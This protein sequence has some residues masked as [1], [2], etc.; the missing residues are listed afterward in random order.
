MADEI[1]ADQIANNPISPFQTHYYQAIYDHEGQD[2]KTEV[3]IRFNE[4]E[5][6]RLKS[7]C[8]YPLRGAPFQVALV[9]DYTPGFRLIYRK[10]GILSMVPDP[11]KPGRLVPQ[12]RAYTYIIGLVE[13]DGSEDLKRV[14]KGEICSLKGINFGGGFRVVM[15]PDG[16]LQAIGSYDIHEDNQEIAGSPVQ[17]IYFAVKTEV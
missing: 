5:F 15:T 14:E 11:A 16:K 17:F 8:L 6:E 9:V 2:A 12:Q 7:F 1:K 3:E 13:D 4:I 10:E